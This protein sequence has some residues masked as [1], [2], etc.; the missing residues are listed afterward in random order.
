MELDVGEGI[1]EMLLLQMLIAMLM[2][3]CVLSG[4]AF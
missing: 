4:T 3:L 1:L 2:V